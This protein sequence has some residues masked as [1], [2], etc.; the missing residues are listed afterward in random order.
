M[1]AELPTVAVE[2]QA[3]VG[4]GGG[5]ECSAAVGISLVLLQQLEVLDEQDP[6]PHHHHPDL[7]QVVL[8]KATMAAEEVMMTCKMLD[9]RNSR[10]DNVH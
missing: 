3:E 7:L 1:E 2:G 6:L 4:G 9:S 10:R 8:L 5:P